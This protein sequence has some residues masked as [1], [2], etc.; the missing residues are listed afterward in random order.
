MKKINRIFLFGDSWIEGQGTY[1]H[2]T[3]DGKFFEPRFDDDPTLEKLSMW[4]KQNSWNKFVK[5]I[6]N[7]E[8]INYARQG[9]DNYS[10]YNLLNSIINDLTQHDL[11]IIGFT[12]KLRDKS[13]INYVW[14]TQA[15]NLISNDNPLNNKVNWDKSNLYNHA[16]GFDENSKH[17]FKFTT[18]NE[19]E[20]TEKFIKDY[21]IF[22]H[23]D[24]TYEHIAQTNYYFYQE[25]FKSLGLNMVC[26]NLF[27][28]YVTPEYVHKQLNID[29]DIYINYNTQTMKEFLE[30]HETNYIKRDE[31]QLWEC[32]FRSSDGHL[33]LHPNQ[34]GYKL[35]IDH[36]FKEFLSTQYLFNN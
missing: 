5:E 14:N 13:S 26:F 36:I 3:K 2:I 28:K 12:S 35:Y 9:S 4:R 22:L 23:N 19:E 30:E 21:L 18:K 10:Q 11:V 6:T 17:T 1:E 20:F 33:A 29:T 8:I 31:I 15:Y 7:C 27:E 34:H 25:R 32:G 24:L 16:F